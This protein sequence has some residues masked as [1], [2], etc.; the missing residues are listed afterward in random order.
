MKLIGICLILL[1]LAL[2][3][4]CEKDVREPGEP[5]VSLAVHP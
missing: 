2:T 5:R 1:G 3:V 4:G